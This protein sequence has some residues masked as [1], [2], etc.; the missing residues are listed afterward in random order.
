MII[1]NGMS[2]RIMRVCLLTVVLSLQS[3]LICADVFQEDIPLQM[4]VFPVNPDAQLDPT[5]VEYL[6]IPENPAYLD[7]S[8]IAVKRESWINA[9]TET[10]LR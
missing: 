9:W 4:Y 3:A 7:P 10:V 5:F 1:P 8:D 2:A 6:A